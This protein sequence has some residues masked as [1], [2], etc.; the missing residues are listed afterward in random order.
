MVSYYRLAKSNNKVF[1]S[2]SR[3]R[4]ISGLLLSLLED[5]NE[6]DI[7]EGDAEEMTSF[8]SKGEITI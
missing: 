5:R 2:R 1:F 3:I 6:T 8:E 4:L 7:T